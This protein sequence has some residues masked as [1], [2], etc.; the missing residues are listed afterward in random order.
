M[1]TIIKMLIITLTLT[2]ITAKAT[3]NST[4]ERTIKT[5][6]DNVFSTL[7]NKPTITEDKKALRNIIDDKLMPNIDVTYISLKIL[8]QNIK[9]YKR[10]EIKT[11]IKNMKPYI[12]N[13]FMNALTFYKGQPLD[14]IYKKNKKTKKQ[15]VKVIINDPKKDI[16]LLF[17]LKKNKKNQWK[18]YNLMAE[19]ISLLDSKRSEF[20]SILRKGNMTNVL[21]KMNKKSP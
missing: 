12:S 21:N 16:N 5:I 1:K 2:T 14:I 18:V 19:G 13:M 17:Y 9:K 7:K 15:R 8:G 6:S 3:E 20:A 10:S 4:P 11:F